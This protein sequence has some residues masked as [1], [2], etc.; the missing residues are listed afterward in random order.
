MIPN[1]LQNSLRQDQIDKVK[2]WRKSLGFP[3]PDDD[4]VPTSDVTFKIYST[5]LG[6]VIHAI[7]NHKGKEYMCQLTIDDEGILMD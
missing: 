1:C 6:D 2:N 3:A 4:C 5:G 7:C